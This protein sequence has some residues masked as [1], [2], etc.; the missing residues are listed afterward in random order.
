M[1]LILAGKESAESPQGSAMPA[2]L[3]AALDSLRTLLPQPGDVLPDD[4]DIITRLWP[5][6]SRIEARSARAVLQR[7]LAVGLL[8]RVVIGSERY[9]CL[10][11]DPE[12]VSPAVTARPSAA[13]EKL[14]RLLDE[15]EQQKLFQLQLVA[16]VETERILL[17]RVGIVLELLALLTLLRHALLRYW[18][19]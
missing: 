16:D 7:L 18:A 8:R 4:L 1:K 13:T 6:D 15:E 14:P 9:L 17:F 2:E 5:R 3:A 10:A 12:P 11:K 19:L